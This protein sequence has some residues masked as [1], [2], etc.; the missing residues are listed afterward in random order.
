NAEAVAGVS[1]PLNVFAGYLPVCVLDDDNLS[2]ILPGQ[3]Y[4][5]RGG[6]QDSA[7]PGNY[8]ILAIDGSGGS[9]DRTGLASGVKNVVG[10]GGY[11]DTKPG[12]TSGPVKQ[13][14]N[15]RFDDYGGGTLDANYYPPDL[16]IK[17]GITYAQYLD[18]SPTQA[19]S[20]E[21][22]ANRRVV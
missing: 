20:H 21:G 7:S 6:P 10:P 11:V 18:G 8:Q 13:G 14:I 9:D 4:T 12:V 1:V 17:E 5:F 22:I 19:P 3:M 2:T 15:T 16:N